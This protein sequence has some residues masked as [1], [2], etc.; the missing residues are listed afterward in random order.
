MKEIYGEK[1]T[2]NCDKIHDYLGIDTDWS[3]DG[4]VST[5]MIKYLC[6][7]LENFIQDVK[8]LYMTSSLDF[9]EKRDAA[10]LPGELAVIF[11][12]AVAQIDTMYLHSWIVNQLHIAHWDYIIHFAVE[13]PFEIR[14][15]FWVPHQKLH[16]ACYLDFVKSQN[17]LI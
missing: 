5:S 4:Q 13:I 1:L 14:D 8:K 6:K 11:Y 15:Q 2:I 7:M 9:K 12:H 16:G 10:K 17:M 3:K